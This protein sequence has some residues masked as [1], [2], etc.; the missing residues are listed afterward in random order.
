MDSADIFVHAV[1]YDKVKLGA[2]HVNG[3]LDEM[4]LVA[5]KNKYEGICSHYGYIKPG[6]IT[7]YKHS[8][9]MVQAASLN[10]DVQFGVNFHADVCN[11][12]LGSIVQT[13]AVNV[14]KFGI[15][16]QSGFVLNGQFTPVLEVIIAKNMATEQHD[17]N[18][19]DISPGDQFNVEILGKKFELNDRKISA[20]GKIINNKNSTDKDANVLDDDVGQMET[21]TPL[22]DNDN[23]NDQDGPTSTSSSSSSSSSSEELSGEATSDDDNSDEDDD[24]AEDDD[25]DDED[26]DDDKATAKKSKK[27]AADD[28]DE[29]MVSDRDDSMSD[30]ASSNDMDYSSDDE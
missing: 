12:C 23:D 27:K 26:G 29:D 2:Q 15:L 21:E 22:M 19:D 30:A 14:N 7:L 20:V 11:P 4:L 5:L 25:D 13:Q 6:S 24:D 3:R 16:A 1:L 10:G 17:V 8:L 28:E 18:V 9:G